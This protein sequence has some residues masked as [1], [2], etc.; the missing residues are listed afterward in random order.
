MITEE[1]DN[2]ATLIEAFSDAEVLELE[3]R[4]VASLAPEESFFRFA[5][6]DSARQC[7]A[8]N[9][10][11]RRNEAECTARCS[12]SGV[13]TGTRYAKHK[14]LRQTKSRIEVRENLNRVFA[15][16]TRR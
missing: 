11:S 9:L 4:I 5:L 2:H 6:D 14:R 15:K 13:A 16:L 10:S 1:T 3:H 12:R 7:R 8:A